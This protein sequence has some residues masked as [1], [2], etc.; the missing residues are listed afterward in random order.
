M[1]AAAVPESEPQGPCW[2]FPDAFLGD[3]ASL[4][5]G[6]AAASPSDR[7]EALSAVQW[8]GG[9]APVR[10]VFEFQPNQSP[11]AA[12]AWYIDCRDPGPMRSFGALPSAAD[13]VAAL[14]ESPSNGCFEDVGVFPSRLVRA[15]WAQG[16]HIRVAH[17]GLRFKRLQFHIVTRVADVRQTENGQAGP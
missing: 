14:R 2:R 8:F 10:S 3:P 12:R 15:L 6:L 13:D 5:A 7:G 4:S 16:Q 9:P 17:A 11:S 1:S